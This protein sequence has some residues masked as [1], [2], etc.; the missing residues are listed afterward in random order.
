MG[1]LC[2]IQLGGPNEYELRY[3]LWENPRRLA[4]LDYLI[5]ATK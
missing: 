5:E 1:T 2:C 4:L 3:R